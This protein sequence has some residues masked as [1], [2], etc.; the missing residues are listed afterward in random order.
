MAKKSKDKFVKARGER[1][2][3][4]SF[5]GGLIF[6]ILFVVAVPVVC[7]VFIRPIVVDIVGETTVAS[8]SSGA[9]VSIIMLVVLILFSTLLGGSAILKRFGLIGV[10]ALLCAYFVLSEFTDLG[11]KLTD[12]VVPV[13]CILI[14]IVWSWHKADKE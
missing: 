8:L 12:A 10:A 4:A 5:V 9:V 14:M 13:V 11:V 1:G 7:S 3:A 2:F 6:T